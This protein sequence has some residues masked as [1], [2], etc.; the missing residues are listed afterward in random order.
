VAEGDLTIKDEVGAWAGASDKLRDVVKWTATSFG[1]LGAL[2]I[3]TAPL[4]GLAK[5]EPTFW[6]FLLLALFAALALG[7]VGFVIWKSTSLLAPSMVTLTDVRSDDRYAGVRT[8]VASEPQAF[9]GTWGSDVESF[10]ANRAQEYRLLAAVDQM[11]VREPNQADVRSLRKLRDKLVARVESLGRVSQRLLAVAQ[12]SELSTSFNEARPKLFG[13]AAAVIFGIAGYLTVLAA[14]S[15]EAAEAKPTTLPAMV[16]LT[17]AGEVAVGPLLGPRCRSPFQA[18][19]LDGDSKGPWEL[20]VIDPAC[21]AGKVNV[22]ADQA[23]V[24]LSFQR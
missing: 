20:L 10:L 18:L 24:Q 2:L 4:S 1:A 16:A 6:T 9:L 22:T 14:S 23:V 3:G 13:G 21:T 19:V 8:L 5:V 17:P 12:F 15:S 11:I 7:G